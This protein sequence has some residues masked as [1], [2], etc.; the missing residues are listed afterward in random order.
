VTC[1]KCF[2]DSADIRTFVAAVYPAWLAGDECADG[3]ECIIRRIAAG[4][5][6]PL[7]GLEPLVGVS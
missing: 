7:S 1:V 5:R 6:L 3:L 4:H 2:R